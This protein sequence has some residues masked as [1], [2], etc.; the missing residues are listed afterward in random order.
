MS[1]VAVVGAGGLVGSRVVAGLEKSGVHSIDL[2]LTGLGKS[3]G[4]S[5]PFRGEN[6]KV[7]KNSVRKLRTADIVSCARDRAS[8]DC[9]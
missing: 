8:Y 7:E 1:T 6:L 2:M 3:V 4:T 9:F 5:L